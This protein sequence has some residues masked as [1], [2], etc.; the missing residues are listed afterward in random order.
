MAKVRVYELAK[1]LGVPS[2]TLLN[3]LKRRGDF[4][5]SAS[6]TIEPGIV[7]QLRAAAAAGD[8]RGPAPIPSST[9][10]SSPTSTRSPE[11][12]TPAPLTTGPVGA[13]LSAL[14]ICDGQEHPAWPIPPGSMIRVLECSFGKAVHAA[15]KLRSVRRIL[16]PPVAGEPVATSALER[17]QADASVRRRTKMREARDSRQTRRQ[18]SRQ[19]TPPGDTAAERDEG[20][21]QLAGIGTLPRRTSA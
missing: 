21:R 13:P 9:V 6:S 4:V 5:R 11:S 16:P 8:W 2:K 14:T 3:E 1:E 19:D 20:S 17:Q 7:R 18:R 15:D 10:P 12:S